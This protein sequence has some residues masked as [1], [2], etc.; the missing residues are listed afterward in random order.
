MEDELQKRKP[1]RPKGSKDSHPRDMTLKPGQ[2]RKPRYAQQLAAEIERNPPSAP[3]PD[4]IETY[5][6]SAGRPP[7]YNSPED[8]QEDIIRYFKDNMQEVQDETGQHMGYRFCN[9]ISLGDLA[10]YLGM[11]PS[12]LR[13]Y[14]HKDAFTQTIKNAKNIIENYYEKA[15]QENRN[16]AGICFIL[17][18]GFGWRDVQEVQV[19]ERDPM[20][21]APDAAALAQRYA[22]SLPADL[23]DYE[24]GETALDEDVSTMGD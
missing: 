16:P 2:V 7:R 6:R 18:N 24:D 8:M 22:A 14:R 9:R 4:V 20:G 17:K 21:P 3:P 13:D 15:L 23:G 11:N 10:I 12:S 5:I 19:Q 1:G